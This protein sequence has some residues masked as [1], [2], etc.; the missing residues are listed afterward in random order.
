MVRDEE[1]KERG[2]WMNIYKEA[3]YV[4][5]LYGYQHHQIASDEYT[6][7][8]SISIP[9]DGL[10]FID[11][12]ALAVGAEATQRPKTVLQSEKAPEVSHICQDGSRERFLHWAQEK[13][14]I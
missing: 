1:V 13:L 5:I 10:I 8:L 12:V 7:W 9:S 11:D 3:Q 2:M 4:K 6:E 14:G